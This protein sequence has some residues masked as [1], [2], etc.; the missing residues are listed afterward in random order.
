MIRK[1]VYFKT[2]TKIPDYRTWKDIVMLVHLS[3]RLRDWLFNTLVC[4]TRHKV[5]GV[6]KN[7]TLVAKLSVQYDATK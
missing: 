6:Q 7:D 5:E 1:P 4:K 3:G 2:P